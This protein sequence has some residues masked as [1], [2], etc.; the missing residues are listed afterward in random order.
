LKRSECWRLCD[1]ALWLP[2]EMIFKIGEISLQRAVVLPERL[3]VARLSSVCKAW[4]AALLPLFHPGVPG[5]ISPAELRKLKRLALDQTNYSPLSDM[6][7][8]GMICIGPRDRIPSWK[9]PLPGFRL[10]ERMLLLERGVTCHTS[11]TKAFVFA[12]MTQLN[13]AVTQHHDLR[14][15][16]HL[17]YLVTNW[18]TP[19]RR[20][21]HLIQEALYEEDGAGVNTLRHFSR[22]VCLAY[23]MLMVVKAVEARAMALDER[24]AAELSNS[25]P[26]HSHAGQPTSPLGSA[27]GN[28]A[29]TLSA[30]RTSASPGMLANL[31]WE[32]HRES[33]ASY[34]RMTRALLAGSRATRLPPPPGGIGG[35]ASPGGIG[36]SASPG[37]IGGPASPGGIGGPTSPGGIGGPAS[38]GGIAGGA[39]AAAPPPGPAVPR[40]MIQRKARQL[41]PLQLLAYPPV[42][43]C[44]VVPFGSRLPPPP[45]PDSGFRAM[46]RASACRFPAPV[47]D[48][49]AALIADMQE[50]LGREPNDDSEE[51]EGEDQ[52][53]QVSLSGGSMI[54]S[55]LYSEPY[56]SDL[57]SYDGY[58]DDD[59]AAYFAL[60]PYMHMHM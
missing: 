34:T 44:S 49:E 23:R 17:I 12:V 4:D 25:L 24:Q 47:C 57:Y 8:P 28:R 52:E 9:P 41:F 10:P 31:A 33:A 36:G 22:T 11:L 21:D 54:D 32:V 15:Y 5:V 51:E 37:G 6:L 56:D 59:E 1:S 2:D 14:R 29:C 27:R 42:Q 26:C 16:R 53:D 13:E 46:F 58:S 18:F 40:L 60:A 38:P 55:E 39:F 19:Q 45:I 48:V 3:A 20:L 7:R 35:P 50:L 43:S 30:W